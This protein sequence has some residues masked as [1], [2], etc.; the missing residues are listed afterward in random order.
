MGWRFLRDSDKDVQAATRLLVHDK[1][2]MPVGSKGLVAGTSVWLL[3]DWGM[4]RQVGRITAMVRRLGEGN[5][6]ARIARPYPRGEPG[7]L[8]AVLN[9]TTA[10]LQRQRQRQRQATDKFGPQLRQ[11]HKLEALGSLA[12]GIAHDF[13]NV[14]GA[15]PGNLW[16]A[17]QETLAGRPCTDRL[18][19]THRAA[20]KFSR[21]VCFFFNAHLAPA[22]LGQV[23]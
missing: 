6:S 17:H 3:A 20:R 19:P 1:G 2:L 12:G 22:E 21:H 9:S 8:M 15:I 11:A 23:T 18:A 13:N 16:L 5:L 4:L 10:P 14:L 7:G